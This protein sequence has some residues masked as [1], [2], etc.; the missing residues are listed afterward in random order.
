MDRNLAVSYLIVDEMHQIHPNLVK[1]TYWELI[2]PRESSD[3]IFYSSEDSE[4]GD[5][6]Y[7]QSNSN[8]VIA[9][10]VVL[11]YESERRT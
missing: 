4:L 9:T 8:Q 3:S 6:S 7:I 2:F 5:P 10:S 1:D 11:Q